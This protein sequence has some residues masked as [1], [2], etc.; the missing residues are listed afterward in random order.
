MAKIIQIAN[1]CRDETVYDLAAN[2]L[3][4]C[5]LNYDDNIYKSIVF[6]YSK[7]KNH[8]A[9]INFLR[10]LNQQCFLEKKYGDCEKI[11]EKIDQMLTKVQDSNVSA[12]Q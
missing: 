9:V 10:L 5:K 8:T 4:S 1:Y 3:Q 12:E 7:S 6:F 11:M 2:F